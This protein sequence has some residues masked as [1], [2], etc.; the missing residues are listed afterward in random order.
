MPPWLLLALA[1]S[2]AIAALYQLASRRYGW[3]VVLYWA[4]VLAGFLGAEAM[5]ESFGW[6]VTRLGDLRLLPDLIGSLLMVVIL[7]FVGA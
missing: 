5:A 3:R 6:S 7:W 1:F 4:L 2:L